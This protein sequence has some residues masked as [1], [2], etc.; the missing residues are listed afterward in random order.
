MKKTFLLMLMLGTMMWSMA[1][2]YSTPNFAFPKQVIADAEKR[3]E[4]AIRTNDGEALVDALIRW[5]LA[6]N[7]I[8]TDFKD[9]LLARIDTVR[10]HETRPDIRCLLNILGHTIQESTYNGKMYP[11]DFSEVDSLWQYPLSNYKHLIHATKVDLM[12]VPTL[13]DFLWSH[14]PGH[15][16]LR[17]SDEELLPYLYQQKVYGNDAL[18]TLYHKYQLREECGEIL[19]RTQ[20]EDNLLATYKDY[21]RRFPKSMWR[22]DIEN[23]V[24]HIEAKTVNIEYPR[25][26]HSG[27][28]IPVCFNRHK[29]LKQLQ[30]IVY[31]AQKREN[32]RN[33]YT[34]KEK[35]LTWFKTFTIQLPRDTFKLAPL[36]YGLYAL[37][38]QF[39]DDFGKMQKSEMYYHEIL[40]ISDVKQVVY[41]DEHTV[42]S[43]WVDINDGHPVE[44]LAKEDIYADTCRYYQIRKPKDTYL[45]NSAEIFTDLSIYRPGETI[46]F[47]VVCYEHSIKERQLL[48]NKKIYVSLEDSNGTEIEQKQ[49]KTDEMGQIQGSFV[50]PTDRMNGRYN[51]KIYS[52]KHNT[53][54]RKVIHVS[55]YKLPHFFLQMQSDRTH[56]KEN[57]TI[58][59]TGHAENYNGMPMA[60]YAVKMTSPIDTTLTTDS[61]GDFAFEWN[62][63]KEWGIYFEASLTDEA[64]ET[65]S[66]SCYGNREYINHRTEKKEPEI[67]LKDLGL[68]TKHQSQIEVS[69]PWEA[70]IYYIACARDSVLGR[71]WLHYDKAGKYTF[72]Q[73]LPTQMD[74]VVTVRFVSMHRGKMQDK[75]IS[76]RDTLLQHRLHLSI[77]TF[78]DR[79]FP[80]SKEQWKFHLCDVAGKPVQGR[81]MLEMYQQALEEMASNRWMWQVPF[82]SRMRYNFI[83]QSIYTTSKYL[84][85][86][87]PGKNW[88]GNSYLEL[89]CYG[90]N[91]FN[92]HGRIAG[93][94]I[95]HKSLSRA[96]AA[97]LNMVMDDIEE[98]F[99][100]TT[101]EAAAN[102]VDNPLASAVV[103][104]TFS[105]VAVRQMQTKVAL[106]Q[107]MLTTD[108]EGNISVSVDIPEDN[109]TWRMQ[110]LAFTEHLVTD[111]LSRQIIVQ[112]PVMVQPSLPRFL[113]QGDET[114]LMAM[115]Q[116]TLS[117]EVSADVLL[118]LFDPRTDKVLT[119][120]I[121]KVELTGNNQKAVSIRCPKK[122]TDSPMPYIG[123]RVKAMAKGC[124]DGEQQML[125]LL[126]ASQPVIETTP[127]YLEPGA[128]ELTLKVPS[129]SKRS[130]QNPQLVTL[131]VCNN[132]AWYAVM[133][134]P[135]VC[136]ETGI[137]S[138][139][140][141]HQLYGLS[142]AEGIARA[143]IKGMNPELAGKIRSEI[144]QWG[145]DKDSVLISP[146]LKNADLKIGTLKA[147]PW[148]HAADRQTLQMQSLQKLFDAKQ[149]AD[150]KD[151]IFKKLSALQ[152]KDGGISW[153]DYPN[154]LSSLYATGE[155]LEL[156]GE[157]HQLGIASQ[158]IGE[159]RA[160][161]YYDSMQMVVLRE[162][163]QN[164]ERKNKI[165]YSRWCDY[166]YI[167]SMFDTPMPKANQ[168]LM[169]KI[170]TDCEK[171]WDKWSLPMRG[172]M[173]LSLFRTGHMEMAQTIVASLKEFAYEDGS[174]GTY[175]DNIPWMWCC[176]N[177]LS[178]NALLLQVMHTIAPDKNVEDAI[179][180]YLLLN[181][182]SNDWGNA[183]LATQVIYALLSTGSDW[184]S[185]SDIEYT[186]RDLTTKEISSNKVKIQSAPNCPVWG[187]LY[188]QRMADMDSIEAYSIEDL[189]IQKEIIGADS[190]GAKATVRITIDARRDM[191]YVTV[192]DL[193]PACLEP[194]ERFSGYRWRLG[195]YCEIKDSETNFF[196][197]YLP[198]GKHILTYEVYITQAGQFKGGAASVQC[199]YAPQLSAHSAGIS[200]TIH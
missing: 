81:L 64:G 49:Y 17:T 53:W 74:E 75:Q 164:L 136:Q 13:A 12:R 46:K 153:F 31:K 85:W 44:V 116:N 66:A 111:T 105:K 72:A 133:A 100:I 175:W 126:E 161:A 132:P 33:Y 62:I 98:E 191:E 45:E 1:K 69:V 124:S 21:L 104:G 187:A 166:L 112:R 19:C 200:L 30:I 83:G 173:A 193:R 15:K 43:F 150:T 55:E 160:L 108:A 2:D 144:E 42:S 7:S 58:R 6:K 198:K 176:Q 110:A 47:S 178:A 4:E 23:L 24:S 50:I 117:H 90:Q 156:M 195:T 78:R 48:T 73:P 95:S 39:K 146:L 186:R 171:N 154:R 28:S 115:V 149:N 40:T 14:D 89:N 59:V 118:E 128:K 140:L 141:A 91:F 79:L 32:T 70:H 122:I 93:L 129:L 168:A 158:W 41:T 125:P 184:L 106:W 131:E 138:T 60:G 123:F 76:V 10:A 165:D 196:L 103:S 20:T 194:V 65:Q 134:L 96:K 139:A 109:T 159:D 18:M 77:E 52:N 197:H 5:G 162:M 137:S 189:K 177:K 63:K 27:D 190:V 51:L 57:D 192:K 54:S 67:E 155:V 36:P 84:F 119:S 38:V 97:P 37:Q 157:L 71:G 143:N 68:D 35:D 127:F 142:L 87:R 16:P 172:Y 102:E 121:Q 151:E 114:E 25:Q 147:S 183:S 163:E 3:Y 185:A 174:R 135:T 86:Q 167:R 120:K 61:Q 148:L 170:I 99:F 169:K 9:T 199:Q 113:R 152:N 188:V 8:S 179:R 29:N 130:S 107:P 11:L 80:N 181:K 94:N 182:Q 92:P 88:L 22:N 180:R 56:Y 26:V 34:I 145:K 82:R 101:E